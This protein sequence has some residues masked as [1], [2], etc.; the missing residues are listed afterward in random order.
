[1]WAKEVLDARREYT[2]WGIL[3]ATNENG[4]NAGQQ[5]SIVTGSQVV[6]TKVHDNGE[7]KTQY[8]VNMEYLHKNRSGKKMRILSPLDFDVLRPYIG[9]MAIVV[10]G[11]EKGLVLKIT[12]LIRSEDGEIHS[13]KG[14]KW[15]FR[16]KAASK[17]VRVSDVTKVEN[18][19]PSRTHTSASTSMLSGGSRD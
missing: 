10:R 16:G 5:C 9:N 11:E 15:P 18:L 7:E 14:K 2:I 13:L 6:R 17:I 3:T 12:D 4:S 8:R 1:M 19:P